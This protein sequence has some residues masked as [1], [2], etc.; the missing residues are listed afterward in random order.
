MDLNQVHATRHGGSRTGDQF[1]DAGKKIGRD[2]HNSP[3]MVSSTAISM[4]SVPID[5]LVFPYYL[6]AQ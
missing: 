6:D 2:F 5:P 1:A 4:L 3:R